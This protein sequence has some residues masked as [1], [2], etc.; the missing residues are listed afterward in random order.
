[1]ALHGFTS[2]CVK[3]LESG[4]LIAFTNGHVKL[5]GDH[6][7]AHARQAALRVMARCVELFKE[8][9]RAEFPD[10]DVIMAFKVFNVQKNTGMQCVKRSKPDGL[11]SGRAV[12][13]A[14]QRLSQ[15]FK[16]DS[17][18][19]QQEFGKMHAIALAHHESSGCGN[20]AAWQHAFTRVAGSQVRS[21]QSIENIFP[22]S[23]LTF[24]PKP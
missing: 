4:T 18:G 12:L 20:R 17:L 15:V 1:M 19:L 8:T 5:L 11:T 21:R 24:N 2:H 23:W 7:L 13:P 10:F 6:G 16:V 14:L 9:V 3:L 22:A